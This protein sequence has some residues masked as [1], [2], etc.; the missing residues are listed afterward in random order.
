MDKYLQPIHSNVALKD[1]KFVGATC[2]ANEPGMSI[3]W[4]DDMEDWWRDMVMSGCVIVTA[5]NG[6]EYLKLVNVSEPPAS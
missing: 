4:E 6:E 3:Q 5:F 2:P 1:G